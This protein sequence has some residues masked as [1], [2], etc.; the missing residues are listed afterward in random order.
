MENSTV[1]ISNVS[2]TARW[3]AY[4]RAME[5]ERP[6]AHF[7]DPFAKRLAGDHGEEIVNKMK[8]GRNNSWPMVVRTTVMDEVIRARLADGCDQILNL[9][10]GLDAR[11]WRMK[12]LPKSLKWVDADL[13]DILQYKLDTLKDAA[14]LCDYEAVKIDLT[15]VAARD[16]LFARVGARGKKTLVITEGLLV[17]LKAS[18]VASLAQALAAQPSFTWW[19]S[20]LASPKLLQ[21]M[22]RGW[23]KDVAKGNA[24]FI[25]G[26]AQGTGFFAPM[27]WR[28][29]E[30][31]AVWDDAKRLNRRMP[32]AWLWDLLGSL[33]G[34][35]GK[36][37]G[38]RFSGTMVLERQATGHR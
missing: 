38:R 20:D 34:P 32:G 18:D 14:P 15:D 5:T 26:P 24:P 9:A 23:G 27:G 8:Q 31:H 36:E 25:F 16:A 7:R 21:W 3:V 2:D 17:Y 29:K 4:Y 37:E 1:P 13:P 35:K 19:M 12:E 11:P 28:E 30:W 22:E 10:C 6:D 33:R